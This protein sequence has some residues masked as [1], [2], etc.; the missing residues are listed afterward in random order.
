[1]SCWWESLVI[2]ESSKLQFALADNALCLIFFQRPELDIFIRIKPLSAKFCPALFEKLTMFL[3]PLEKPPAA[4][5]RQWYYRYLLMF[6][7]SLSPGYDTGEERQPFLQLK[8]EIS[9]S[10]TFRRV[11]PA[12]EEWALP[13]TRT[14]I[15]GEVEVNSLCDSQ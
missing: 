12:L 6:N 3:F 5:L 1:M 9:V 4:L 7:S 15:T 2:F 8:T 11:I 13:S 10:F 14:W